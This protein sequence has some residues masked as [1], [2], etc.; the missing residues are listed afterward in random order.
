M[1]SSSAFS[2]MCICCLLVYALLTN[3]LRIC[4]SAAVAKPALSNDP[5]CDTQLPPEPHAFVQ[6]QCAVESAIFGGAGAPSSGYVCPELPSKPGSFTLTDCYQRSIELDVVS[7]ITVPLRKLRPQSFVEGDEACILWGWL[8]GSSGK[9]PV[10]MMGIHKPSLTNDPT[11]AFM[12]VTAVVS[13]ADI[14]RRATCERILAGARVID[15]HTGQ[16]RSLRQ[17]SGN[18]TASAD[19]SDLSTL[20]SMDPTS[21]TGASA[22]NCLAIAY[23]RHALALKTA[24]SALAICFA[25]AAGDYAVCAIGCLLPLLVPGPVGIVATFACEGLCIY[26]LYRKNGI[27]EVNF[28]LAESNALATLLLDLMACGVHVAQT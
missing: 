15:S 27:C 9:A 2:H 23:A 28:R 16:S 25:D 12:M 1:K 20:F 24:A 17:L 26:S 5:I 13:A 14:E 21:G 10:V 22:V 3:P 8:K 6:T 19:P 4:H 18:I 7:T 11:G